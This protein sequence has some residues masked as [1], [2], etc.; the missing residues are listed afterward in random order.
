M[1]RP[2]LCR[3]VFVCPLGDWQIDVTQRG[4]SDH[5]GG[6]PAVM[7]CGEAH[8]VHIYDDHTT[9]ERVAMTAEAIKMGAVRPDTIPE[10]GVGVAL[11]GTPVPVWWVNQ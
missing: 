11:I 4:R 9:A 1:S 6:A 10:D 8:R 3:V 2:D 7:A 5:G